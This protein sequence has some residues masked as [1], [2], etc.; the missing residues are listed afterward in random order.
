MRP[1]SVEVEDPWRR[2]E[3]LP[4]NDML[5][6]LILYKP[7]RRFCGRRYLP[8]WRS[9]TWYNSRFDLCR[10]LCTK[11]TSRL[12]GGTAHLV[13]LCLVPTT[14]LAPTPHLGLGICVPP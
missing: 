7:G 13:G 10:R 12:G 14:A 9:R 5:R 8:L 6:T 4:V 1:G 3:S 2:R 11:F